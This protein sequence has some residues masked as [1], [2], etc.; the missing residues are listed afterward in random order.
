MIDW[1]AHHAPMIA[2]FGFFIA[3]VFIAVWAYAP[4]NKAKLQ[5]LANIPLKV[6]E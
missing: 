4:R 6:K 3:F 2:L 1:L 5:E